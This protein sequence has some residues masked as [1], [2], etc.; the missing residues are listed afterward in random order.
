MA[1][2]TTLSA[3]FPEGV[4]YHR[5]SLPPVDYSASFHPKVDLRKAYLSLNL[6]GDLGVPFG[7][8]GVIEH[9][10]KLNGTF[11]EGDILFGFSGLFN[12]DLILAAGLHGGIIGDKNGTQPLMMGDFLGL[13]FETPNRKDILGAFSDRLNSAPRPDKNYYFPQASY[14]QSEPGYSDIEQQRLY[15]LIN[16]KDPVARTSFLNSDAGYDYIRSLVRAGKIV[17][18][19]IDLTDPERTQ[20]LKEH[21]G[22][23]FRIAL[24]YTSNVFF[25]L[26]LDQDFFLN[27]QD[28]VKAVRAA[29]NNIDLLA[30][31]NP[32]TIVDAGLKKPQGTQ[33][34]VY[35]PARLREVHESEISKQP[36]SLPGNS[37]GHTP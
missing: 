36:P 31:G 7:E 32:I 5:A 6:R 12:L 30:H 28:P 9:V 13:I 25:Y 23:Q 22:E 34:Q 1:S 11:V 18:I 27:P 15:Q 10:G 19:T 3:G 29:L 33:L 17:P 24:V 14:Y 4:L 16:G 37:T 21:L 20:L 35:T 8:A 26:K 2:L